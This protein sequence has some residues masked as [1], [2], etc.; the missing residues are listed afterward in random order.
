M[1]NAIAQDLYTG[2]TAIIGLDTALGSGTYGGI[3]GSTYSWWASGTST[4][5]HTAANMKTASS[6]SYLL[7]LL[8]AGFK[9]AQHMNMKPNLIL[10]SQ[11]VFDIAEFISH[12]SSQFNVPTTSR[13]QKMASLGFTTIEWRG[14]PMVVDN[15]INDTSDA[16]YML[17]TEYFDFYFHPKDNFEIAEFVRPANQDSYISRITAKLQL[18]TSNRRMHYRWTDLNN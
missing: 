12:S 13:G 3:S 16:M 17:N 8:A 10:C 14:I 18:A 11:D 7:T 9:S 5:A 2:T 1:K 15:Y 4:T 6:T